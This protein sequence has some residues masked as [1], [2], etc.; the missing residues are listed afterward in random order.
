MVLAAKE[1]GWSPTA[2]IRD[3]KNPHKHHPADYNFALA[4]KT[5]LD[6]KCPHCGVPIW[7][8]FSTNPDIGFKLKTVKCE[9]C[10]YKADNEP[11]A[12]DK[13]PGESHIVYAVPDDPDGEL[14]PRS[15]YYERERKKHLAE[16]EAKLEAEAA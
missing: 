8:A 1:W 2:M 12:K 14:P 7:Y 9:A 5:L 13:G 4:V 16:H 3:A 11:E 6:E 15:D 10:V